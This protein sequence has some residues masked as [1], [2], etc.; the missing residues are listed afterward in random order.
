MKIFSY[1]LF[2]YMVSLNPVFAAETE[3]QLLAIKEMGALY[4]IALPCQ[5]LQQTRRIKAGMVENL[6]KR[7]Y[8]GQVFEQATNDSFLEFT[9]SGAA[10]PGE[11]EMA[12]RVD[13]AIEGLQKNFAPLS[14]EQRVSP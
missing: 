4:G 9:R 5:Y 13:A 7:R 10:C 6:P 8:L 12:G 14:R 3:D 2:V 11:D 1:L